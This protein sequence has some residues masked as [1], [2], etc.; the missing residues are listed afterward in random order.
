VPIKRVILFLLIVT[1]ATNSFGQTTYYSNSSTTDFNQLSGWGINTDGSGAN[2]SS[3]GSS[4]RLVVNSGHTKNTSAVASVNR[5]TI[6]S[7]ATVTANHA[8]TLAGTSPQF[9]INNL[10]LYIHNNTGVLSST[11]FAGTETFNAT[12]TFQINNWQSSTTTLISN[13]STTSGFYY[14]NLSINWTGNTGAWQQNLSGT[15][16]LTANNFTINSTGNASGVLLFTTRN[17]FVLNIAGNFT[18]NGGTIEYGSTNGSLADGVIS[19]TG[20]FTQTAGIIQRGATNAV[21]PYI[22]AAGA[23]TSIWTITGGTRS[24]IYS[25]E[26]VTGK[27]VQL[28]AN[29]NLGSGFASS[30]LINIASGATLDAQSYLISYG[31]S[32]AQLANFGTIKTS[33]T[34]GLFG[35]ANTTIVNTPITL[36]YGV[37]P[38]CTV[39]YYASGS[40]T[41]TASTIYENVIISGNGTKQLQNNSTINKA[42]TFSTG[43]T[44][45]NKLDIAYFTLTISSTGSI[46]N[47]SS[48]R[49]IITVPTSSSNGRLRQNNISNVNRNH[50]PIGT[51]THY[52]P[53]TFQGLTTSTSDFSVNVFSG[54]TIDGSPVGSPFSSR[55]NQVNAI[56]W[57]DRLDGTA[58]AHIQV[59]WLQDSP[60]EGSVFRVIP[61]NKITILRFFNL[62]S[63]QSAV[64]NISGNNSSNRANST[65]TKISNWGTAGTGLP[66]LVSNID[67]LAADINLF[68]AKNSSQSNLLNWQLTNYSEVETFEIERSKNGILFTTIAEVK[69]GQ[70]EKYSYTDAAYLTGIN[71]YR[72]KIKHY[73]G[74]ITY[75]KV[76]MVNNGD[77]KGYKII[78]NPV[79]TTLQLIHPALNEVSTYRIINST[80]LTVITGRIEKQ[81]TSSSINVQQLHSGYYYLQLNNNSG[82]ATLMPFIKQ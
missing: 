28:G 53:V 47:A 30:Y 74:E 38:D 69:A 24:L 66:Y 51:A 42:L 17:A 6:S 39:E 9:N 11:I 49:Y 40:Q 71:Y 50:F 14:G 3:F 10:G 29:L 27:T 25:Y 82:T 20:N 4:I 73:N 36:V 18:I 79:Q 1:V 13:L 8:I 67:V 78:G 35:A 77:I 81:Q 34:N 22:R 23:G 64:S 63:W 46:V 70:T 65:T 58:D 31:T 44:G 48:D 52:L 80:G 68:T 76:V 56:W 5:L 41:V 57:I 62:S 26:I 33:N 72:L 21:V 2:P 19:I 55:V 43:G 32:G 16:N 12:S 60:L 45:I 59:D 54:T 61:D 15:V 75:S 37:G 7:G